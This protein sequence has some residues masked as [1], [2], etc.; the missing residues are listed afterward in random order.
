MDL[1][2]HLGEEDHCDAVVGVLKNEYAE[3]FGFDYSERDM[4]R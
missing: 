3:D 2:K 4:C 1:V